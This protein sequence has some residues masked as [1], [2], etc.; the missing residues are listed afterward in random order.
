MKL[1]PNLLTS[2]E[3]AFQ[4]LESSLN[5]TGAK[6]VY[7]PMQFVI[8]L[9]DDIN[10]ALKSEGM[11]A[12][13]IQAFSTY[14]HETIHWWQHVGSHLGFLTSLSYPAMAHSAHRDLKIMIEKGDKVKPLINYDRIAFSENGNTGNIELNTILNY[15]YDIQY[16][17]L[18]ILDNKYIEKISQDNRFFLCI[19][20]CFHILWSTSIHVV[21]LSIDPDY[22]FLPKVNQWPENFKKLADEK[23][24]G[25]DIDSPNPASTLGTKAIYEGQARFNQ[26]QYLAIAFDNQYVY[27]DFRKLGMLHGIYIEAFDFFLQITEIERPADFNNPVIGLFLLLCDI[28]INPVDGF[29]FDITHYESFI[30]SNDPG[31]RFSLLCRAVSQDKNKWAAAVQNY[32][33]DEYIDLTEKL[34]AL[35]VCP[36]PI[37]G[38]VIVA[39]W[40]DNHE[41]VKELLREENEMKYKPENMEIRLFVSKYIRFQ[42]DKLRYPQIFCWT[43]KSMTVEADQELNFEMVESIFNKHQALFIDESDGIIKPILFENCTEENIDA[44]FQLFY[45][46]N[47]MHD[48][49]FKWIKENGEFKYDYQWLT[50]E[51]SEEDMKNWIRKNFKEVFNIFPE[52]LKVV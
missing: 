36:P 4:E 8:R 7:N 32:S 12:E 29:P 43:G 48:M 6:G 51:H 34:C 10:D 17:K 37:Y 50:N 41:S 14:M 38:S 11:S 20:H 15:Y 13:K 24:L 28:A 30:I 1:N 19:G 22:S 18:F 16:A 47:T 3:T 31:I 35:I 27:E 23:A 45:A 52:D 21:S 40:E 33:R 26:L 25:F 2:E 42:Q 44:T 9:R 49:I 39:E 46:H 5:G